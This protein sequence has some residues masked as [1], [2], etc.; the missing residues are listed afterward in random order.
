MLKQKQDEI[1]EIDDHP[2]L[3]LLTN[4]NPYLTGSQVIQVAQ[5]HL[6]LVGDAMLLKERNAA[7]VPIALW[8]I[9]PDWVRETPV[10]GI[11]DSFRVSFRGWNGDI[12]ASE[13]L[14]ISDPNPANPYGRGTGAARA[15]GDELEVDEYSA[16]HTSSWFRNGARPDV[17]VTMEEGGT[18]EEAERLELKWTEKHG[19]FWRRFKPMFTSAKLDVKELSQSFDSMSIAEL[20]KFERDAIHQVYGVPPEVLGIVENSNRATI[21]SGEFLY[22]KHVISPR[23]EALRTAFQE[24]LVPEFDER[25]IIDYDSPVTEDKEYRLN[26]VRAAQHFFTQN[27]VRELGGFKEKEDGDIYMVPFNLFPTDSLDS[28]AS[29]Q[30]APEKGKSAVIR[31]E[32]ANGADDSLIERVVA[33]IYGAAMLDEIRPSLQEAIRDFGNRAMQGVGSSGEFYMQDPAVD[34]YLRT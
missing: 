9:P 5:I 24:R 27:E 7:G 15:L 31:K 1:E 23:L 4:G 14:W 6:D 30:P 8:P 3:A 17:I 19:G 34:Y 18:K 22:T 10:F 21:E 13:I 20:R 33:A 11:R 16:K 12:P 29:S 32:D 26:V 28:G 2:L 25:I